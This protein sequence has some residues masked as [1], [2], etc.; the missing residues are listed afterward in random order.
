MNWFICPL[1]AVVLLIIGFVVCLKNGNTF[2]VV[3]MLL[4]FFLSAFVAY[5]PFFK[6]EYGLL[7]ALVGN[8]LN[9]I[10][11]IV[12]DS[13]FTQ[14]IEALNANIDS[15]LVCNLYIGLLGIINVALP[16]ISALTAV[17]LF[18]HYISAIR[19]LFTNM[20]TKPMY[21]L[22]EF[23]SKSTTFTDGL[24]G[25]KCDIIFTGKNEIPQ[26]R[27]YR[28]FV[29]IDG[30]ISELNINFKGNRD[31]YFMCLDEDE[32]ASLSSVL[33]LID[34]CSGL[35][36]KIQ[37][38]IHIYL[39]S[40]CNDYSLYLDSSN[41][42]LLDVHCISEADVYVYNLLLKYSLVRNAR[43]KIHV[44]LYGFSP[45]AVSALKAVCWCGQLDEYAL[46]I[47]FIV[48]HS[49]EK[50]QNLK[51]A[52]PSIFSSGNYDINIINCEDDL[53]VDSAVKEY[54]ADV[55]Y[56]IVDEESDRETIDSGVYLRRTLCRIDPKKSN[57]PP[58]FCHVL[59]PEKQAIAERLCTPES[60][61]K[62]RVSYDIITFGKASEVYDIENLL[63]SEVEQL[64][65]SVH[66]VYDEIFSDGEIDVNKSLI[67]YNLFEV[68]KKSNRANAM[69]IKYKL[70]LLGLDFVKDDGTPGIN[71]SDYLTDENIHRLAVCE[72]DRWM[73]FLETEGW[74]QAYEN[75]VEAYRASGV[76]G[77]RHNCPMLKMHPYICPF[78]ELQ[79]LSAKLEGK[80]TTIYDI[81]LVKRIPDI[82]SNKWN[83]AGV[84]Y[85]IVKMQEQEAN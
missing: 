52:I 14:S 66:L 57:R 16:V 31:I 17:E 35:D 50:I 4:F 83:I 49:E 73:A 81:E 3:R 76:S 62:R 34:N 60:N 13:D 55:N 44:L 56:V 45:V 79:A 51:A 40:E 11:I 70:N 33:K 54:C 78:E 67:S 32:E 19:F 42:G 6:Q 5:F 10:H 59:S 37:Q 30:D 74:V 8:F 28:K 9:I 20:R 21:V 65:K 12:I 27:E 24:K 85:K 77:N 63:G 68:N 53:Q 47:T 36:E 84:K 48:R 82:L 15:Q 39:F 2:R 75:D 46:K 41:K 61:I 1:L 23:N 43:K 38:R 72:H 29:S 64:S 58:I 69:H 25:K 7:A 18:R 71:L 26:N 80:D 22:S